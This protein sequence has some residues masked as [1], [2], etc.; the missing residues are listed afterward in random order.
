MNSRA[1]VDCPAKP[2]EGRRVNSS[3]TLA[4]RAHRAEKL[5]NSEL[6]SEVDINSLE[7]VHLFLPL[8]VLSLLRS[9]QAEEV[10]GL[11]REQGVS[12]VH[13]VHEMQVR[14]VSKVALK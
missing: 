11:Q 2:R 9:I 1:T 8:Y 3:N 6:L 4:L 14:C 13:I 12:C 7:M 5:S 10:Q